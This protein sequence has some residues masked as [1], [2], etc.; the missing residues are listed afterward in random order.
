MTTVN[1]IDDYE[2]DDLIGCGQ[3]ETQSNDMV[4]CEP[5]PKEDMIEC[6]QH[7][8]Q[9]LWNRRCTV[10]EGERFK[11]ERELKEHNEYIKRWNIRKNQADIP[12]RF[13]ECELSTYQATLPK[14][15]ATLN[16]AKEF[17]AGFDTI[18][19]GRCFIFSGQMGT[20]KTHL[21]I[22]IANALMRKESCYAK[23][24]MVATMIRRVR[25]TW[26]SDSEVSESEVL[27]RYAQPKLLI[28]DEVGIQSGSDNELS[29]LFEILNFRYTHNKSTIFITN[30]SRDKYISYLGARVIDRL[31]EDGGEEIVFDWESYRP[32]LGRQAK[33]A[34][35]HEQDLSNEVGSQTVVDN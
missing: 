16:F 9:S 15:I 33:E 7:G 20:G 22:A 1:C 18:Y 4:E 32:I 13:E 27:N 23:Y 29:M 19:K 25:A 5:A 34:A 11:L 12:P 2:E 35:N 24:T 3:E 14:Q 17:V 6:A 30:L 8:W 28:L 21:A 31:R 26:R 10:C